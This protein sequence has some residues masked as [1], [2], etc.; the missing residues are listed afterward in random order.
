MPNYS[1]QDRSQYQRGVMG[2]NGFKY[3]TS[4]GT[5]STPNNDDA[6]LAI[7]ALEE[8]TITTTNAEAGEGDA[9]SG[10]TIPAGAIIVGYFS[11]VSV[12]SGRI[13]VYRA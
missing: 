3:L 11:S 10:V 13:L 9:L 6:Y 4:G 8:A 2:Q 12:S 7:Q 5:S 1:L